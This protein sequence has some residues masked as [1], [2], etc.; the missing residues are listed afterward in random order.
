MSETT[1]LLPTIKSHNVNNVNNSNSGVAHGSTNKSPSKQTFNTIKNFLKNKGSLTD[2]RV[3]P[4]YKKDESGYKEKD[5]SN[6]LEFGNNE[7][8]NFTK[9]SDIKIKVPRKKRSLGSLLP[10]TNNDINDTKH[11]Y[12]N[13]YNAFEEQ[14]DQDTSSKSFI[15]PLPTPQKF[16][17]V[18]SSPQFNIFRSTTV[19]KPSSKNVSPTKAIFALGVNGSV[20]TIGDK[21]SQITLATPNMNDHY[22]FSKEWVPPNTTIRG[23]YLHDW[24]SDTSPRSLVE[25]MKVGKVETPSINMNIHA[26]K[27]PSRIDTNNTNNNSESNI[28]LS[29]N[30]DISI[31][32]VSRASTIDK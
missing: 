30:K 2:L 1:R 27:S 23:T 32:S 12:Y 19:S 21:E 9:L 18:N 25:S 29:L 31:S 26:L 7:S 3:W 20:S 22:S 10:S 15:V 16:T 11:N 6:Y 13:H 5:S 28:S 4:D 8:S 17:S 24:T 14:L